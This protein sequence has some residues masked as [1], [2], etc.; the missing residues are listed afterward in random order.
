MTISTPRW[1]KS[2]WD[3]ERV[4]GLLGD[5]GTFCT[6]SLDIGVIIPL[7][8]AGLKCRVSVARNR[9]KELL[10]SRP[11]REGLWDSGFA[12]KLLE[13]VQRIEE[14]FFEEEKKEGVPL[15]GRLGMWQWIWICTTGGQS[16]CVINKL[17]W[18]TSRRGSD[19]L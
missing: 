17:V 14:E 11:R 2:R 19:G 18:I 8:M 16:W 5:D 7:Y 4:L 10:L 13:W 12:A 3:S 6:F 15:L 9:V 1:R